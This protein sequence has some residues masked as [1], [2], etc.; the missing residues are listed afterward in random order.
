M[1][2]LSWLLLSLSVLGLVGCSAALEKAVEQNPDIVFNAIKKNPKKFLEV[3]NE[4][5]R[6]AQ[7]DARKDEEAQEAAQLE[8][9]FKSPKNPK[10]DDNRIVFGNKSA[11]ITIVEYSDFQCPYCTRGFENLKEVR[12]MYGD[13]VRVVYKH[14]PLD[15]HPMAMPA[16]KYFEALALQAPEKVEKFHD[17]IFSRQQEL[18]AKK[19]DFLKDVAK[20]LGAN[21]A[22]LMKDLESEAVTKKIAADME[23]AREF[24]FNGTPGFLIN[25]VSLRGAYPPQFFQKIIDRHLGGEAKKE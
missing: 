13:K 9:E 8:E 22:K 7:A 25:G 1:K 4:A 21:M 18:N 5:A 20:K 3:V 23:E 16:A 19:E 12:K 17:E 14:L 11:P 10:I 6:N 2:R 15:G 24:G